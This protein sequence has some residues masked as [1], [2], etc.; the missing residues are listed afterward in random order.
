VLGKAE[1]ETGNRSAPGAR[2]AIVRGSAPQGQAKTPDELVALAERD[3]AVV[4]R[5][6]TSTHLAGM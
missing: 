5:T 3:R 2:L 4:D 6:R 1:G